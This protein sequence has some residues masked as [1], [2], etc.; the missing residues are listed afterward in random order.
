MAEPLALSEHET[1]RSM[2]TLGLGNKACP[3]CSFAAPSIATLL[4]HLRSVHSMDPHFHVTCGID[5]CINTSKTFPALYSHIYR[6]HPN[7][8]IISQRSRSQDFVQEAS[9]STSVALADPDRCDVNS[10]QLTGTS[11]TVNIDR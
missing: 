5:G 6:H 2:E 7:V 4:R 8:G 9:T 3:M 10:E 1:A 11:T